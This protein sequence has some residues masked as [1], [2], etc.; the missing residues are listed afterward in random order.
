VSG[1]RIDLGTTYSAY[2]YENG[3]SLCFV[4]WSN[5]GS[6]RVK[7]FLSNPKAA[8]FKTIDGTD[9]TPKIV[10]GGVEVLIG[11]YPILVTGIDEIPIPEP[12]LTETVVRFDMLLKTAERLMRNASEERFFFKDNTAGFDRNPG[13]SF[14]MLRTQYWKLNYKIAGFSWIEAEITKEST[15]S[16]SQTISGCSDNKALS[17][18]VPASTSSTNWFA[19][20]NADIRSS[21]DLEIWISARIPE[22]QRA[23]VRLTIGDQVYKITDPPI[24]FYSSGFGWYRLGVTKLPRVVTPLKIE[25]LPH[26]GAD[27]SIDSI[28]LYPGVF[29]PRGSYMPDAIPFDTILIPKKVNLK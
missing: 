27:L 2:R 20:Y 25:V 24:A 16:E 5:K 18:N 28:L 17:L 14:T 22:D 8:V 3:S 19:S 29:V 7:L 1:N 11:E 26:D 10:K 23:Y 4:I 15:F 13:G 9:P 21:Q 6:S 12:A